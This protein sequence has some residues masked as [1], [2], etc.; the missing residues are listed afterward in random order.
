M[1]N[2]DSHAKEYIKL[3]SICK[4]YIDSYHALYN[5][6]TEKEEE[7][8]LIY[9]KIKTEF[10]D[11]KKSLPTNIIKDILEI[12]PYNNR[13]ANS[14]L[15]L[16]KLIS[17]EYQVKE[18]NNV[19]PISSFLFFKK[20]GI[21]LNKSVD[22]EKIQFENPDI[23]TE[24]TIYRAIMYDDLK[25]FIAFTEKEGFN[26][27]R[28]LKCSLYPHPGYTLLEFCCYHGAV[29]C[30]K[31]LRTK[32]KSEITQWCLILSFLGRNQEIMSECLKYQKPDYECMEFAIISHNIDFVAF[33]MNEF[34]LRIS[35]Y[36]CGKYNNL[37]AFLVFFDQTN[38]INKCFAYSSMFNIPSLCE[39]FLSCGLSIN[40]CFYDGRT[41]LH[42][43]AYNN[44]K[45]TAE[46]LISHGA[47]I[48]QKDQYKK[49]LF[50]LQQKDIIKKLPNILFHMV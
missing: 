12:I 49:P 43:A 42:C 8:N 41:A 5:L 35:I 23:H 4:Y 24:N 21:K 27:N 14:Y 10:I 20:Y 31:F 29:D 46:Y 39:F 17:D 44:S 9:N 6:K 18:V 3:L 11:S 15:Y 36:D 40:T 45:E 25:R 1:S 34:E 22:F 16:A 33:L 13:Y 48:N 26:E 50:I 38:D 19:I 47:N 2:Q 7:L 37:A 28:I 30:F 32:F